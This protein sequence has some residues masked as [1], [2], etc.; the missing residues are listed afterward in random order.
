MS[1]STN[2]LYG[3]KGKEAECR[4]SVRVVCRHLYVWFGR[5]GTNVM[6]RLTIKVFDMPFLPFLPDS[7]CQS[8]MWA[9]VMKEGQRTRF[10]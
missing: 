3:F 5:G 6:S 1:E 2:N 10:F 7:P 8:R 4:N 9:F